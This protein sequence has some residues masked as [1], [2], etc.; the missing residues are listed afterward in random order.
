MDLRLRA[1][2]QRAGR[3]RPAR[4]RGPIS[5]VTG[6]PI[7]IEAGPELGRRPRRLA[8]LRGE[9]S[10]PDRPDAGGARSN[11][12]RLERLVFF[13]LP[14]I[15]NHCLNPACV[16]A[17]PSGAL[18]KRGED[19][20]VLVDQDALPRLAHV[21]LRPA[22]TRRCTSTG[23]PASR[24]SAS[25]AIPRLE[26]GQAPACFHSC[27]GRIRYLGVLLYDARPDRR[28]GQLADD[29]TG[30]GAALAD[31]RSVRSR[32]DRRGARR[33]AS[34]DAVIEAAQKSPVYKYVKEWRLALPL[35]P[36]FRTLPMLFYVPP[37]L[38]VLAAIGEGRLRRRGHR[39]GR[40]DA[41]VHHARACA[42]PDRV[43]GEP[44]LGRQR[45]GRRRGVPASSSRCA[46]TC[47]RRRS[48]MCRP[49]SSSRRSASA[50]RRPRRRTRFTGSRRCRPRRS[51]TCC[52]R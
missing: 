20:I 40:R 47:A 32:G 41:A 12:S 7:E 16:A 17:C 44:L 23:T 6:E 10:E 38:P 29:Q 49:R 4:L 24:R 37:M 46:C 42:Y 22:P 39:R 51:A 21:R 26:T 34:H 13:Y 1:P 3:R 9:R 2:V 35:H 27:V 25:S 50:A 33:T 43:H 36:E 48:A 11:C 52:R 8:D 5:L 19:G 14:R 30:R 18:Y 31:P 28:G 45:G 15:C